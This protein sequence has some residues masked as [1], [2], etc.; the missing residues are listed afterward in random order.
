MTCRYLNETYMLKYVINFNFKKTG[1]LIHKE[2]I[3]MIFLK[4][5]QTSTVNKK[6]QLSERLFYK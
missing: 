1:S 3:T 2:E 4:N 6:T 5:K